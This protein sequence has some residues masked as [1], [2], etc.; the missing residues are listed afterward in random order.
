MVMITKTYMDPL[1]GKTTDKPPA[2]CKSPDEGSVFSMPLAI[3]FKDP[4]RSYITL[5]HVIDEDIG[6]VTMYISIDWTEKQLELSRYGVLA[7]RL[8][9]CL[10]DMLMDKLPKE[11]EFGTEVLKSTYGIYVN[12][13]GMDKCPNLQ[14]EAL[15]ELILR[16]CLQVLIQ[17]PYCKSVVEDMKGACPECRTHW[18]K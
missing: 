14:T 8:S 11:M 7:N 10:M 15:A 1:T 13:M 18:K 9:R 16:E 12:I 3:H 4:D 5:E 6:S 2:I 17:C